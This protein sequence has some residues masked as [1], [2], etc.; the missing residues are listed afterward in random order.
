[1]TN[2]PE[3]ELQPKRAERERER[4]VDAQPATD[5]P[6]DPTGQA[7][8]VDRARESFAL[9]QPRSDVPVPDDRPIEDE[10]ADNRS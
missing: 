2:G 6:S 7:A 8:A 10:Q 3:D 5:D 9:S 4:H 1:M